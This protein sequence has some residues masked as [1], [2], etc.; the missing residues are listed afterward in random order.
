LMFDWNQRRADTRVNQVDS[1]IANW[2]M[3][4]S[5]LLEVDEQFGLVF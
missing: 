5:D 3:E 4:Y 1:L 2:A